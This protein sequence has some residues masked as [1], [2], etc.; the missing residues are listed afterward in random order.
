[1]DLDEIKELMAA[2]AAS[3]LAEMRLTRGEWTLHLVRSADGG[4]AEAAPK[5]YALQHPER[6]ALAV[7]PAVR[8]LVASLPVRLLT[9]ALIWLSNLILP[10][11]GRSAGPSASEEELLALCDW[12][13]EMFGGEGH[14]VLCE[15]CEENACWDWERTVLAGEDCVAQME[16]LAACGFTVGDDEA[17]INAKA[18]DICQDPP[19]CLALNECLPD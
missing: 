15:A 4:V 8:V 14:T 17:C 6:T 10:G 16:S 5:T 1:M 3:D 19:A 11:K 2:F 18:P 9:R 7:A 13:A 12:G